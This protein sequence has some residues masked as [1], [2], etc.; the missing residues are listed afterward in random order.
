MDPLVVRADGD[1]TI[2]ASTRSVWRDGQ[3]V[4]LPAAR[5]DVLFALARERGAIVTHEQL[6]QDT[7]VRT[8]GSLRNIIADLRRLTGAPI[9][10]IPRVGYVLMV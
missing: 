1:L 3:P 9:R 2:D 10:T 4:V 8:A 7:R 6:R 5:F